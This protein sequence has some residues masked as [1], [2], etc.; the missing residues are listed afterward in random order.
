MR[1]SSAYDLRSSQCSARCPL[2]GV[3][4]EWSQESTSK[5]PQMPARRVPEGNNV[6]SRRFHLPLFTF[7]PYGIKNQTKNLFHEDH[8]PIVPA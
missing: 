8:L 2:A 7:N 5:A 6:N 3:T 4:E 1:H